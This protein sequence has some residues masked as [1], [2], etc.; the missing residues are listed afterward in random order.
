[1]RRPQNLLAEGPPPG[2][3]AQ[4]P[5]GFFCDPYGERGPLPPLPAFP[6]ASDAPHP[7]VHDGF[8]ERNSPMPGTGG[9]I[10]GAIPTSLLPADFDPDMSGYQPLPSMY[11]TE[12]KAHPMAG[13]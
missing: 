1:M 5:I 12:L 8:G 6:V 10:V 4:H 11:S 9:G 13:W 3:F 7:L 2:F